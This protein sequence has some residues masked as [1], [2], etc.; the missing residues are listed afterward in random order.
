[1]QT[2]VETIVEFIATLLH[3]SGIGLFRVRRP[4]VLSKPQDDLPLESD[5]ALSISE[6]GDKNRISLFRVR[7]VFTRIVM[8]QLLAMFKKSLVF[9]LVFVVVLLFVVL[10]V[11]FVVFVVVLLA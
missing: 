3:R 4:I 1:M 7:V 10:F 6:M 11:V 9:V 2:F 5:F 8:V